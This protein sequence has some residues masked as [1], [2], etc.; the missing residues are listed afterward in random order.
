MIYSLGPRAV[1][2]IVG[3][4]AVLFVTYFCF[5]S[6]LGGVSW[7]ILVI[8]H[9]FLAFLSVTYFPTTTTMI[10]AAPTAL[11]T[12]SGPNALLKEPSGTPP[13]AS[14]MASTFK[15]SKAWVPNG[16]SLRWA[17][18]LGNGVLS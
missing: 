16:T 4:V 8:A 11:S 14:L 6:N 15:L 13:G 3:R 17:A 18:F 1:G 2:V 12:T 9:A 10:T 5:Y 7:L